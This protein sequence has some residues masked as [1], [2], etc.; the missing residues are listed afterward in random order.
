MK[1]IYI[2]EKD[3]LKEFNFKDKFTY[4]LFQHF[5]HFD[6]EEEDIEDWV[7][8]PFDFETPNFSIDYSEDLFSEIYYE[9]AIRFKKLNAAYG[10]DVKINNLLND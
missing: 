8:N 7:H 6:V 3:F 9:D 2:T 4:Q 5:I 1:T 10:R